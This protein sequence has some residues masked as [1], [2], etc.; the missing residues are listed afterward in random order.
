M[1]R[2]AGG[3]FLVRD[4]RIAEMNGIRSAAWGT[5]CAAACA[6]LAA[7]VRGAEAAE[8]EEAAGP[9]EEIL[10]IGHLRSLPDEDVAAVSGFPKS[11]LETPR[12]ASTVSEEMMNRFRMR[13][14][15]ELIALAPGTFTQSFFG[16]AGALDIRGTPGETYFRG[17]RRLDN[18]AAYPTPIG[19]SDRIDIVRGPASPIFGPAKMGGYLN[20]N[21][22]SARIE[23]TGHFIE[24]A[25]GGF[26]LDFGSWEQ[27]VLS[28]EI[29][30]PAR[31]GTRNMGYYFYAELEDSGSFYRN[32]GKDQTL[33]QASFDASPAERLEV[34]FG[35]MYQDFKG[36]ENG[37][38]NRLT[39]DLIDHGIYVTGSPP[40]LDADG[41]GRISHQEYDLDGDGF[42][43]LNPFV[44]GLRPGA[45]GALDRSGPLPGTCAIGDAILFGCRPDL[46]ALA[47]PGQAELHPSQV[48]VS[49][50]DL[51]ETRVLTLYFDLILEAGGDWELKNQL[52]YE[53][54]DTLGQNAYG[55]S[56]F[57]DAW[58]VENKL[59]ASNAFQLGGAAL[60]VQL[61]PSL[62]HTDFRHGDDYTNEFFDRR[63]LTGPS[64]ALDRRLLA[65]EID[66]DYTEYYI[67]DYLDLGLAA[68]IDLNW[69]SGLGLLAGIRYD[70][71]DMRSRQPVE[72]LLLPSA[73]NFC[74]PPGDCVQAA[75]ADVFDGISWT[76]SLSYAS[77]LGLT[78][79]ATFSRQSTVI[80]GQ[81][82]EVTTG[83][84]AAG[85]AFD[86]SK[87]K[88]L[89][90]K[91]SLLGDALYFAL[92][93][94]E[95]ERA[96]FSAQQIVTNQASRTRGA[97][98]E[99]RWAAS[100]RLLLTLGYSH[101]EVVN[102]N[103]LEAGGRF[104][105]IG[106]DDIPGVAPEAFY[107]GALSGIVLRPG[108]RGARRAGVPEDIWYFTGTYDFGRGLA[109]SASLID[110]ASVASGFSNSIILPAYRLI[111]LGLNFEWRN[112]TFSATAKNL[113]D[114]RYFRSNFPN[115]FGGVVVLPELPRHYAARVQYRW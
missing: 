81:G 41:D 89:G 18:L 94:Y 70:R 104:S 58:V 33:L 8:A 36:N 77:R 53:T 87:L 26:G 31:F 23:Q 28:A 1:L 61:S 42:T 105:F 57:H 24:A 30:G 67:G 32:A 112:W 100:E 40:P 111:N 69:A 90:L 15:D 16:A 88:E 102:L 115:L 73:E 86:S 35:G 97:E 48:L 47:N 2:L 106:A 59:V 12:S 14:I 34:Q 96:D 37:G 56:Q 27:K 65:T 93:L 43:D 62:R 22:K 21:P 6:C 11:L 107:G 75:A 20:F 80:A 101:M 17:M 46:L 64:S 10:V 114:E 45:A 39:Q 109:A 25:T 72:K 113:A 55:F 5:I 63:D 110:V 19:A 99:L 51:L 79:Y 29:G 85:G 60:A 3:D 50:Q 54:Y 38:W 13:D 82:A 78:P 66:D 71:L 49:A 7:P 103:S 44:A 108:A 91:G 83:N 68:Q 98:F 4:L 92:A 95:Q 76:L 9:V 52:F 84:I 74:R